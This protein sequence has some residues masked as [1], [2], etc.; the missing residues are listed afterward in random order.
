MKI[1]SLIIYPILSLSIIINKMFSRSYLLK[2]PNFMS[3]SMIY[4]R[5]EYSK[6]I[7]PGLSCY[8]HNHHKH[9]HNRHHN[10]H[11][12]RRNYNN[13]LQQI[14]INNELCERHET[15]TYNHSHNTHSALKVLTPNKNPY[16]VDKHLDEQIKHIIF[17]TNPSIKKVI[18]RY[19]KIVNLHDINKRNYILLYGPPGCG[20]THLASHLAL[21]TSRNLVALN[22]SSIKSQWVGEE[23][24]SINKCL[25]DIDNYFNDSIIIVD[26]IDTIMCKRKYDSVSARDGAAS[27]NILLSWMDGVNTT[28]DNRLIIFTTNNKKELD[29]AFMDR[30]TYKIKIKHLSSEQMY[31][32]WQAHLKYMKSEELKELSKL[33]FKSFRVANN[34]LK[35]AIME[36]IK[37]GKYESYILVD[38]IVAEYKKIN[39]E[40]KNRLNLQKYLL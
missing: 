19:G 8:H 30:M 1:N 25:T 26:E 17:M 21:Q 20:K 14:N 9:H 6:F 28:N 24:K 37:A 12:N 31:G 4:C 5:H 11:N 33:Q 34:I 16:V 40:E 13:E 29:H 36:K 18:E 10:R 15:H 7:I 23:P 39:D 22:L 32:F 2:C 27:V 3:L 38:D 35:N